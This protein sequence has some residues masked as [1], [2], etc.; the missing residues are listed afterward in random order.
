MKNRYLTSAAVLV[1]LLAPA[2]GGIQVYAAQPAEAEITLPQLAAKVDR[3][4]EG[5]GRLE[6]KVDRNTEGLVRLEAKV[7]RNTE[8]LVRLEAKVDRNTEGLVRLEA[9]NVLLSGK[10]DALDANMDDR[11]D[12]INFV[13]LAGFGFL[14]LVTLFQRDKSRRPE[15]SEQALERAVERALAKQEWSGRW[16]KAGGIADG[17]AEEPYGGASGKGETAKG[18]KR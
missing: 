16:R 5:L 2:L 8:G 9:Q 12:T 13:L 17:G 1:A 14:G 6:T 4:T 3:N 7:D 18:I 10:I 11:L 15:V